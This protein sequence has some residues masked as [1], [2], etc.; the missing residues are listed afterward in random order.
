MIFDNY[1]KSFGNIFLRYK[2]NVWPQ[3]IA[4]EDYKKYSIFSI[5]NNYLI[6]IIWSL[7]RIKALTYIINT[8]IISYLVVLK[9]L[10]TVL[11]SYFSKLFYY[12]TF[13]IIKGKNIKFDIDRAKI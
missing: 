13:Y 6:N 8:T 12:K 1:W 9:C 7:F 10:I 5:N 2:K 4:S 11:Y 3:K